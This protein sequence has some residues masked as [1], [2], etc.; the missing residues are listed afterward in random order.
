MQG[1]IAGTTKVLA[2]SDL[3]YYCGAR[4]TEPRLLS[5]GAVGITSVVSH[6]A[7]SSTAR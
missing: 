7:M 5:I 1:D 4:R 2:N 6:V 3:A